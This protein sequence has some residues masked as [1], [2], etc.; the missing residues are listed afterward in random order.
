[1]E[2]LNHFYFAVDLNYIDKDVF[3]DFKL[4]IYEI[5]NQLNSLQKTQISK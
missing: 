1:M 3:N 4:K 2:V 5:S